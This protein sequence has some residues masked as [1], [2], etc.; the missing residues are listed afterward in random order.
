MSVIKVTP[1]NTLWEEMS[2]TG[3]QGLVFQGS[4]SLLGEKVP[5]QRLCGLEVKSMDSK[6]N[7][8][9]FK[10]Q[11]WVISCAILDE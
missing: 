10:S 8:T 6:A 5:W 2:V 1:M 11:L 3:Y 4:S 7:Q 9:G